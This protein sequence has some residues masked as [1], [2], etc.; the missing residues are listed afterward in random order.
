MADPYSISAL[1][2]S[3]LTAVGT[4]IVHY[5]FKHCKSACCESDCFNPQE[6]LTT[7][8]YRNNSPMIIQQEP[9]YLTERQS[10]PPI[11][12]VERVERV[13][14]VDGTQRQL[15]PPIHLI[16]RSPIIKRTT[17][18]P[19]SMIEEIIDVHN[20]VASRN[21]SPLIEGNYIQ[22]EMEV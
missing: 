1:V 14:R 19:R 16:E 2:I 15:T 3:G 10:T 17:E 6:Q 20:R 21:S 8:S 5:N 13:E 18:H 4:V 9:M 12:L 7:I 22:A 11:N